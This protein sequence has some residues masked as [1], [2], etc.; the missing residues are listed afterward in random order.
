[1][2]FVSFGHSVSNV[3]C[4]GG[5]AFGNTYTPVIDKNGFV[6]PPVADGIHFDR[7]SFPSPFSDFNTITPYAAANIKNGIVLLG[8]GTDGDDGDDGGG[9]LPPPPGWLDPDAQLPVG[10][11]LFP[12]LL[13]AT[14]CF[15]IVKRKLNKMRKADNSHS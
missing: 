9:I 5:N 7:T 14:A 2:D 10:D 4:T 15:L 3:S 13:F 11:P 12:L 8:N 6:T 1:M